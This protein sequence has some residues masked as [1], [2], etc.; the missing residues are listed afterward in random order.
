MSALHPTRRKF[1]LTTKSSRPKLSREQDGYFLL[2]FIF[3]ISTINNA[4]VKITINSSYVLIS[5]ILSIRLGTDESTS[6]DY[7]GKYIIFVYS[8]FFVNLIFQ[9]GISSFCILPSLIKNKNPPLKY[10]STK[11]SKEGFSICH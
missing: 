6:P 2:F 7:P 1:L 10:S 8:R 9:I 3:R 5:I 4:T 11:H